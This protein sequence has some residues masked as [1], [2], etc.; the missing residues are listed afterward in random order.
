MRHDQPQS[1][2]H[3]GADRTLIVAL[4][5]QDLL[6]G[7][8]TGVMIQ[9]AVLFVYDQLA[10]RRALRYTD[11]LTRFGVAPTAGAGGAPGGAMVT[12]LRPF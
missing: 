7:I 2:S 8:G 9:S 6:A 5:H 11:S 10:A 4:Q 12:V 3:F 1:L